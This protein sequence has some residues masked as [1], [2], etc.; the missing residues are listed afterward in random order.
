MFDYRGYGQSLGLPTEQGT[1]RD[2]RAAYEVVRAKYEDEELPPVVLHGQSLGGAVAIQL[3]LDKPVRGLIVESV[4]SSTI[5]MGQKLYPFLPV[6]CF[7]RFRYD[8]LSK[9]PHLN[10]PKLF[11]H[12]PQD[13]LV[14][15]DLG[16]KLYQA[17]IQPKEFIVLEGSHN[18]AG[19]TLTPTY[20]RA[21]EKFLDCVLG[22]IDQNSDEPGQK[23]Q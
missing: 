6:K 13:D 1:Y 17:A 5:D 8:S 2:A 22:P 10:I 4:F 20:W 9:V 23:A 14:P 16:K 19:W 3:A 21:V 18:D 11:A 15:Y 7:C 12:S